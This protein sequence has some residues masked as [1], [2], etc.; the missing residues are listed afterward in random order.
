M[1]TQVVIIGTMGTQPTFKAVPVT[2]GKHAGEVRTVIEFSV[3]SEISVKQ[4]DGSYKTLSQDWKNCEYWTPHAEHLSK[5]LPK[6]SPLIVIGTEYVN[7]YDKD[8][9]THTSRRIRVERL[10]LNL[11]SRVEGIQLKP[12]KSAASESD[13]SPAL[14]DLDDGIQF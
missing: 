5:L 3:R 8:G 12:A 6:G 13:G 4:E 2:K 1:S 7:G 11:N 10:A 14:V 9:T